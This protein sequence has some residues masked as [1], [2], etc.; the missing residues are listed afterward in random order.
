MNTVKLEKLALLIH[1]YL[2]ERLGEDIVGDRTVMVDVLEGIGLEVRIRQEILGK[3]MAQK[4]F[5]YPEDWWQALKARFAPKWF[6]A[7]WPVEV[8]TIIW[9][10]RELYP[11]VSFPEADPVVVLR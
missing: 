7:R 1:T 11:K 3:V 2:D 6:L 9:T 4:S 10:A 8:T 5:S